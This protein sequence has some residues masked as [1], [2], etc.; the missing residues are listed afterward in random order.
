MAAMFIKCPLDIDWTQL[1][2]NIL[3]IYNFQ[4]NFGSTRRLYLLLMNDRVAHSCTCG[5]NRN[6]FSS[7]C[8]FCCEFLIKSGRFEE[9]QCTQKNLSFDLLSFS[10][11]IDFNM[12]CFVKKLQGFFPDYPLERGLYF[13][14]KDLNLA[15]PI[16][17]KLIYISILIFLGILGL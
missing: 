3:F 8:L 7:L 2:V 10:T 14:W 16:V 13:L 17:S 11:L 15:P 1:S 5:K 12:T 9:Y 4:T 6:F